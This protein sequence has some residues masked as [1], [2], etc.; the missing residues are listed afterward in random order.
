MLGV[1]VLTLEEDV[2][3]FGPNGALHCK[4]VTVCDLL[5]FYVYE[6][7]VLGANRC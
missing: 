6:F 3:C 7:G 1:E 4:D 5:Q 2:G